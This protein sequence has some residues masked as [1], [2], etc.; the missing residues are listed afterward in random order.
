VI[1]KRLFR[2]FY[3]DNSL[4]GTIAFYNWVRQYLQPDAIVL[5]LGAGPPTNDPVRCLKGEAARVIGADIDPC[6]LRNHELDDAVLVTVDGQLPFPDSNFDLV[7]SDFVFEHVAEPRRLLSEVRRVLK[8]GGSFFFRTPNRYH[9]VTAIAL[10]TP[11]WFHSLVANK[12]R[13]MT[14]DAH[15]PWKTFYLL[16]SRRAIE[17]EAHECGFEVIELRTYEAEP[18][19]MQ[20][21]VPAFL[22]G[23]AYE[24]M[25]NRWKALAAFRANIFGRLS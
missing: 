10:M 17:K 5:N 3:P 13:G 20:F 23:V 11:H 8:R 6:V 4:S 7:L 14:A 21:S 15:E 16:N 9:Y 18:M 12:A 19:Y 24:R 22:L 1:D 2:Q 25:V